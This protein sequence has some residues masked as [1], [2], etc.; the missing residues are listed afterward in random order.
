MKPVKEFLQDLSR[1]EKVFGFNPT[2]ILQRSDEWK[3]IK[4]GVISASMIDKLLMKKTT[5]GYQGYISELVAQIAT[6]MIGEEINAKP[7]QWG[8]DHEAEARSAYEFETGHKVEE[9]P[10]IFKDENLRAGA[11]LDG[12]I[13]SENKVV[14]IKCPYST[15]T[16][17][18]FIA[19]GLVKEEYENQ[20]QF[21]MW[22]SGASSADFVSYDPR[23]KKWMLHI[24]TFKRDEEMMKKFDVIIPEA[25]KEIDEALKKLGLPFGSQWTGKQ[26]KQAAQPTPWL[27]E[28]G[29]P[30]GNTSPAGFLRGGY[31]RS[32]QSLRIRR[33][34]EQRALR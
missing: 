17:I 23:M 21:Q 4:L 16:H 28:N 34:S 1:L 13:E 3:L 8:K 31:G 12:L 5:K 20:M 25:I 10:F 24:T 22:V 14:E 29:S 9:L 18:D 6:G 26:M 2:E 7:L 30:S 11:S 33:T 15:K 32:M 27:A 19:F